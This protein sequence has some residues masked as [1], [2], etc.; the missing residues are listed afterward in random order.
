MKLISCEKLEKS[1]VELQFSIDAETFKSAVNTAFK[2]EG[3]KFAPSIVPSVSAP[4]SMNFMLP[5]PDASLEASEICSD[6]SQA[7]MSF[8]AAVTLK[9][10]PEGKLQRWSAHFCARPQ[11][12]PPARGSSP[13][14]ETD[15]ALRRTVKAV[16]CKRSP[17]FRS[18]SA[19]QCGT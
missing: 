1:M 18:L 19:R 13:P 8:S 14:W 3:K 10:R 6:R 2:R 12:I 17:A 5:V 16:L 4:L 11:R 7:G 9:S 15:R